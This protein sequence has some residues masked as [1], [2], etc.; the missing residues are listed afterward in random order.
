MSVA[1]ISVF[2]T[3]RAK[4]S[5]NHGEVRKGPVGEALARIFDTAPWNRCKI[6]TNARPPEIIHP[7]ENK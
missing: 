6:E 2:R 3:K 1:T 7:R 4:N 5:N